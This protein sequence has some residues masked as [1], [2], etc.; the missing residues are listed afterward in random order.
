LLFFNDV[1]SLLDNQ[2]VLHI[3]FIELESSNINT[4]CALDFRGF[5]LSNVDCSFEASEVK[6]ILSNSCGITL[7][8]FIDLK[9][10]GVKEAASEK[11]CILDNT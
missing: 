2:E 3:V 10:D 1:F 6:F 11:A 9:N 4:L 7:L 8:F 5:T